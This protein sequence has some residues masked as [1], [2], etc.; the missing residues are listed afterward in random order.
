MLQL[1]FGLPKFFEVRPRLLSGCAFM[2]LFIL[3]A[4]QA[5]LAKDGDGQIN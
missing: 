2:P 1:D 4:E 3:C 5:R